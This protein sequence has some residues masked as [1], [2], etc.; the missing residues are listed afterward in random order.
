MRIR[1]AGRL[2]EPVDHL[3]AGRLAAAGRPDQ[4]AD[5]AG[6]DGQRQVVDRRRVRSSRSASSR[7]R[8]RRPRP[9]GPRPDRCCSRTDDRGRV[10][11][12]GWSRASHTRRI[13]F[14]T[15]AG[16]GIGREVGRRLAWR[17]PPAS[18][19]SR[20]RGR[21]RDRRRGPRRRRSRSPWTISSR[22]VGVIAE[23]GDVWTERAD[24]QPPGRI[25]E[26]VEPA[27]EGFQ[28][29]T[30]VMPPKGGRTDLPDDLV[31]QAVDHMVQMAQ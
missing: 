11:G 22:G 24:P 14:R 20:H 21:G 17:R 23:V 25:G 13:G 10:S 4:D 12:A 3:Q 28:G 6:R 27:I 30:G 2:D 8:G 18:T 1:P 15:R 5:L 31:K 19:I 7:A 26:A 9:R 16:I 29:K